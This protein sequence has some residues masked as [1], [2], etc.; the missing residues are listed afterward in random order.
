MKE[1]GANDNFDFYDIENNGSKYKIAT[2]LRTIYSLGFFLGAQS[3]GL[4]QIQKGDTSFNI[5]LWL[6]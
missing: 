3:T 1:G 4:L 2:T 6:E 5:T